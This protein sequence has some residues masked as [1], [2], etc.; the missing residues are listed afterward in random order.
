M[1]DYG[2]IRVSTGSQDAQTQR[3]E[4]LK[5]Y[6]S[7]VIITTDTKAASASHGEQLDALDT[8]MA[9]LAKGDRLIVTDSSRL[10]R[11]DNLDDQVMTVMAI[12]ATGT[13]LVSLAPGEENLWQGGDLGSWVNQLVKQNINAEKSRQV[14]AQV[15]RAMLLVAA[16]QAHHGAL[17]MFWKAQGEKYGKRAVCTNPEAI[18]SIY[19]RVANGESISAIGREYKELGHKSHALNIKRLIKWEANLT[20]VIKYHYNTDGYPAIEWTHK[21]TP[22]VDAD[23]WWAANRLL[24]ANL[25]EYAN[26]GGRPVGK[27]ESWLTGILRCPECGGRLYVY[28]WGGRT[29][30]LR[31]VGKTNV[32]RR[33]CGEFGNPDAAPIAG[34]VEAWF[35][36]N[37]TEVLA[38]KR[39]G[40]NQHILDA[41]RSD[42]QT[43]E[44]QPVASIPKAD[45]AT[46]YDRLDAL[47]DEISGFSLIPDTYDFAPT[48]QTIADLWGNATPDG[49]RAMVKA[50]ADTGSIALSRENDGWRI[51]V[52]IPL[53]TKATPIVNLG[54]GLCFR[55][56]TRSVFD[57]ADEMADEGDTE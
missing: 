36:T 8:L 26:K 54:A 23:L 14:K 1:T 2:F 28:A 37:T 4:I 57:M 3:R 40:G 25:G 10:D 44:A 15:H 55:R 41:L 53:G 42:L 50:V 24:E 29:P 48:G 27:P 17:P 18:K 52:R 49:R 5:A 9:R 35:T 11:R 32:D 20:G 31:C 51:R 39:I 13:T 19:T 12:K 46:F 30:K 34:A 6:P 56:D 16:N 45:R 33:S 43:L 38:Y 7:A 47:Q 22:V 21:V